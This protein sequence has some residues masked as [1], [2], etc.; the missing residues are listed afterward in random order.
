MHRILAVMILLVLS[1]ALA[2]TQEQPP[3]GFTD[4]DLLIRLDQRQ[5]Q[6]QLD[7][8]IR[9]LKDG[10][11]RAL[12]P[13]QKALEAGQQAIRIQLERLDKCLKGKCC[14]LDKCGDTP[15]AQTEQRTT[16]PAPPPVSKVQGG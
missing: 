16:T 5:Q 4:R 1:P 15:A 6:Q 7:Q 3:T 2:W 10:L 13:Q 14:A 12:D 11:L 8:A 9:G